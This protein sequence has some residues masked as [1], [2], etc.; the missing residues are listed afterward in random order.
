MLVE[1]VVDSDPTFFSHPRRLVQVAPV[2]GQCYNAWNAS[3]LLSITMNR[4]RA[5]GAADRERR[6]LGRQMARVEKGLNLAHLLYA[7]VGCVY[8]WATSS[9]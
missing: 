9:M 3:S 1:T 8:G 4:R 5:G 2:R 7:G 6:Q